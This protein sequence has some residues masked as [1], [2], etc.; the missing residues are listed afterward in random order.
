[1]AK[2]NNLDLDKIQLKGYEITYKNLAGRP[3]KNGYNREGNRNFCV[4]LDDETA[5]RMANDGWNVRIKQ[6]DDGSRRNT[7]QVA[8]RYDIERYRPTVYLVTPKSDGKFVKTRLTEDTIS[9]LD[10]ATIT[11][12]RLLINP[13][14]WHDS[15]TGH[16]R[17]KAYLTLGYFVVEADPFEDDFPTDEDDDADYEDTPF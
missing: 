9:E 15:A 12:T 8:V 1:M 4:V 13:S 14:I 7:L 6:F 10:P 11:D 16:D 3:S 2:T 5:D 17:V